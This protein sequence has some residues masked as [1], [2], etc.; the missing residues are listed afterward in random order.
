MK[1]IFTHYVDA[2]PEAVEGKIKH[3]VATGLD[4]AAHSL[5]CDRQETQTES[6]DMGLRVRG[7]LPMFVGSEVRVTGTDRLTTVEVAIP[8]ADTDAGTAKLW[9][10][11][12]FAD[13]VAHQAGLAA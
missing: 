8:W 12:R 5:D 13:V 6:V 3:A 2:A 9:A 1:L 11:S 4:T 10:A 7:G